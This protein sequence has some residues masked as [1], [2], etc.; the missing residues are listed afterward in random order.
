MAGTNFWEFQQNLSTSRRKADAPAGPPA[1]ATN[2]DSQKP[3]T[4]SQLTAR[5][6]RT[7]KA[8]FPGSVIVRGEVSNFRLHGASGH[9]YFTLKD[10]GACIDC[11]MFR[12]EVAKLRFDPTDGLELIATGRLSIFAQRGR[13]QIQVAALEP[14]GEGALELARRQIQQKLEA[15]GLFEAERKKPLPR[16]PRR[17]VLVT[18]TGTAAVQDMLK[19]LRRFPF[20]ELGIYHVP[21]QGDG[22]A[23]KIAAALTELSRP[24][25][26]GGAPDLILWGWGGGSLEDLWEFNEEVVARAI[27]ASRVPVITGIGHEIDVSIADLVADYH[28]HTP[29]E[30]AQVAAAHW[31]NARD[32]IDTAGTRLG[33]EIRTRLRDARQRLAHIER[34]EAF[35]RPLDRV[36]ALRQLLDDRQRVMTLAVGD[37][38]RQIRD[39]VARLDGRLRERHPRH[40][41][42]LHAERLAGL[43]QRLHRAS[44]Q[45][46]QA[47]ARRIEVLAARLHGISP[48]EVLKRGYSLTT[49]KKTGQIIRDP[50]QVKPGDTLI[51]RLANG[52]IQS[53]VEDARQLKLFD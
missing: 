3:L 37:R 30:A 17:I 22:S 39:R 53:R 32:L 45:G 52:Q 47:Y 14:L 28:A 46:V 31:R 43:A 13:Y 2:G 15:E 12:S 23:E 4:I 29:T 41:I 10:V 19:V 7:L 1:G 40:L 49:S 16:Y 44:G 26:V 36:N 27:A 35:R 9:A 20:I 51:T 11:V 25:L 42:A 48:Q 34:H 5:I 21:V 8:G 6:E 24:R 50:A 38:L 18:S 33:R